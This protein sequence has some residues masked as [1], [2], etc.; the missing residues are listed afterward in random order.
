M[1][2]K[3]RAL[4][5]QSTIR[6]YVSAVRTVRQISGIYNRLT[7]DKVILL[8]ELFLEI[9]Y[10]YIYICVCVYIKTL[11]LAQYFGSFTLKD[12]TV[13]LPASRWYR[14]TREVFQFLRSWCA[15]PLDENQTHPFLAHKRTRLKRAKR[16]KC[17]LLDASFAH[18]VPEQLEGIYCRQCSMGLKALGTVLDGVGHIATRATNW[19]RVRP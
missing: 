6:W 19:A 16:R 5:D 14:R 13:R 11:I 17:V 10:V 8:H 1:Q 18:R 9:L 12:A 4:H 3:F 7:I 15:G 2:N